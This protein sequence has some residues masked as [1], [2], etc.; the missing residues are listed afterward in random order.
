MALSERIG[1]LKSRMGDQARAYR[2]PAML[3]EISR[4]LG[5][6]IR[7]TALEFRDGALAGGPI[8]LSIKGLALS[9]ERAV[10][11]RLIDRLEASPLVHGVSL[12]HAK[13]HDHEGKTVHYFESTLELK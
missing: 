8:T 10:L 2:A 11:D 1:T 5:S 13:A 6:D 9:G 4:L 7:L 12:V 3:A